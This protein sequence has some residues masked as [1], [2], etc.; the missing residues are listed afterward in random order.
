MYRVWRIRSV[1][2][3]ALACM[4][5]VAGW[6]VGSPPAQAAPGQRVDLRVLLIGQPGGDPTTQSW[7]SA[8]TKEGVPYTLEAVAGPAGS[9]TFTTPTLVDP[10]DGTHGLYNG[11]VLTT[12][13]YNFSWGEL[14][15]VFQYERDFGIRQIDGY[16]YPGPPAGVALAPSGC[17]D[18]SGTTPTLTSAGQ[19]LFPALKGPVPMDTGTYG[20][21]AVPGPGLWT[22]DGGDTTTPL[23]TDGAGNTLMALDVHPNPDWATYQSGISELWIGFDYG[24]SYLQWLILSPGLIDW[25]TNGA[26]LGLSRNYFGQNVDDTFLADNAWSSVYHCTPAA[27][28]PPD[29][30]CPAGVA[31]NPADTPADQ[32]MTPADVTH[33]VEWQKQTGITLEMAF[34]GEGACTTQGEA[35]VAQGCPSTNVSSA[36][37]DQAYVAAMLAHKSDFNWVNHT[38]SHLFLGCNNF[39]QMPLGSVTPGSSGSLGAGTNTYEITALTAYGESETSASKSAT[40]GTGG[41]VTLAWPD[42]PTANGESLSQLEAQFTGGSG[43]WGYHVYRQNPDSSY[44]LVGTVAE[45]PSG[46][47]PT[48]H[49]TDTGATAP[50]SGPASTATYP[51]ATNPSILCA[52]AAGW[53]STANIGAE[54]DQ[55]TTFAQANNLPN[56]DLSALV[57]GEHSGVENPN[58]TTS[59][60]QSGITSFRTDASR[61]PT[62][63]PLGA[64]SS[65]PS[66][67]SNIYYNAANWSQQVD[68]YN[69]LYWS[70]A[71]NGHCVNTATNTCL[72][73]PATEQSIVAS[74]SSIEMR[75]VLGNDPRVGYAHQMN[76][77]GPATQTVGGVTSDYG[78]TLLT[79]LDHVKSQYDSWYTVPMTPV[80][81]S[82]EAKTLKRQSAWGAALASGN[83]T[84][85]SSSA[86]VSVTNSTGSAV[87][88]PVS[89]PA[90]STLGAS[91]FGTHIGLS[92]SDWVT[93]QPG[94]TVT[95]DTSAT[96][97]AV[98]SAS[99]A[100][101]QV[102]Q[103]L[104]FTVTGCGSNA[105][106]LA[107]GALPAGLT[108][109]AHGDGTATLAGTPAPGTAVDHAITLTASDAA[110]SSTQAFTLH[111]HEATAFT[112]PSTASATP[113]IPFSFTVTTTGTPVASL[114]QDGTLPLGLTFTDNGDGTAT[115]TGTPTQHGDFPLTLSAHNGTG[116]DATQAL[117][118]K[119]TQD[120]PQIT[121]AAPAAITYRTA[122]TVTQLDATANVPGTFAY[123]PPLTTVLQ[124]GP[125]T[126]SV[127]FTPTDTVRYT[128]ATATVPL[129]VAQGT[130]LVTWGNP[131]AI[132]YGTALSGTEL[133]ASSAV[134]GSF[135]YT[136][137]P[138]TV[139]GAGSHTLSV[140]FA[141]T[142]TA[143][144]VPVTTTVPLTVNR[145]TPGITWANP[146]P[147]AFGT[148]LGAT[149]LNASSAVAGT[150]AYTPALGA[151]LPGGTHTLSVTLTPTD[152]TD[153][154]SATVTVSLAV[155]RVLPGLAW[156]TPPRITYG[157][158]LGATQLDASAAV[159]GSFAY[160][161]AAGAV[162]GAGTR[163][164]SV[165]FTPTDTTDYASDTTTVSLVVDKATPT[166]T[167]V[168]PAPLDYGNALGAP[169][170]NATASTGGTLTYTPPAG[171]ILTAGSHP[172]SVSFTPTDAADFTS[173]SGSTTLAVTKAVSVVS[174]T[175]PKYIQFGTPLGAAQLDANASTAGT[176]AYSPPAGTV[177]GAGSRTLS[178]TFTPSDTADYT[179]AT[180]TTA[181]LVKGTATQTSLSL[182]PTVTFANQSAADFVVT[183][184]PASGGAPASGQL[185]VTT[186]TT[187]L[188]TASLDVSGVGR[189]TLSP[190]QLA[191]GGHRIQAAFTGNA[192]L[193]ASKSPGT[194]RLLI[195][196]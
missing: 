170:L 44:G 28:N 24:P 116:S 53:T 146:A 122:L 191:V 171:T 195:I 144:Y 7:E 189:C 73:T 71:P 131:S 58:L 2:L 74:E 56:I 124:A 184:T 132:T 63:Y 102:G 5:V 67:P 155:G 177:L 15:T 192:N 159:A 167:W 128:T 114:S 142:D 77:I 79:F 35:P 39:R 72:D 150:F 25:L 123:A 151:V 95:I 36:P 103:A 54:V 26:H 96:D 50:G 133:D 57:T 127:T 105:P 65:A 181:L 117:D 174:W 168:T 90:G 87:D 85:S 19:A 119:V 158:P 82:S 111:V 27:T 94:A 161:P 154:T 21:R 163:T 135:T 98:C 143:D 107:A 187:L 9:F 43:F 165:T 83:V 52:N 30:T 193:K 45:D 33:V 153:Y 112:S 140:T 91:A 23:L 180:A 172:L 61:Q 196:K 3:V 126:L 20:C 169:Q 66:Y 70:G 130:P 120:A 109:A 16:T 69:T 194:I 190:G 118:L 108:F 141:P 176:F 76:L 4:V 183:V 6:T 48:Y 80:T 8:L 34:N 145:A 97:P 147:I 138:G 29:T 40:V 188:C 134:P 14:W 110:G 166:V 11:V 32:Q 59:L 185:T 37:D 55:N 104:S 148:P 99:S 84:A 115:V 62:Q 38:W 88:V 31:N 18:L 137:T 125:Q 175:K 75:H 41:S 164:L 129:M 173:A 86:G 13:F 160:T 186:G 78:Y 92:D 157:T 68:E 17:A 100:T 10:A 93:V 121:W 152:A 81:V 12:S 179:V 47:T 106:A 64:A 101:A 49:F 60:A 136:P 139:L 22:A 42:A 156:A 162:V 113:G 1:A 182:T 149:Q 178:L 51:T 46:A 89:A